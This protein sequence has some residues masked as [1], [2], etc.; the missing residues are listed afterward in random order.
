MR[1]IYYGRIYINIEENTIYDVQILA[2]NEIRK[3]NI[4]DYFR[5][6]FASLGKP[7]FEIKDVNC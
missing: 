3:K 1:K 4:W 2:K 7:T 6:L 5:E